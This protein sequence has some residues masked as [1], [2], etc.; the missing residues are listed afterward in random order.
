M[1]LNRGRAALGAAAISCLVGAAPA[2]VMVADSTGDRIALF[3]AFDG[4]IINLDWLSDAGA[5]GW[6]FST[7]KEA[8]VIGSELWVAD[9]IEDSILRFDMG[10]HNFLG[11]INTGVG[12]VAL[13]N[14]RSLGTDGSSRVWLTTDGGAVTDTI[15]QF[16]FSGSA[17]SS[18]TIAGSSPFDAELRANGNL[19]VTDTNGVGASEYTTGGAFVSDFATGLGF[20]EQ[21]VVLGDDSVIIANAIDS[22]GV[23]G[24]WHYNADGS[25][26]A[27]LDTN[28]AGAPGGTVRGANLL[29]NGDYIVASSTGVWTASDLGGGNFSWTLIT[30]AVNGQYITFIPAPGTLALFG[31][32]SLALRRRRS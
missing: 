1:P 28:L 25:V 22:A 26:R 15:T 7:P 24:V 11:A 21:L 16:D 6:Q 13:D 4:S 27:F 3:D 31:L 9:Q 12:G 5:V 17:V 23:E 18:F 29:G 10:S 19:L 30:D 2:Q 8:V 14:L 20:A 32:G